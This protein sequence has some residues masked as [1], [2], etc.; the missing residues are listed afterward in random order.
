MVPSVLDT[1]RRAS[2]P[3]DSLQLYYP[4]SLQNLGDGHGMPASTRQM[5]SMTRSLS[6]SNATAGSLS[7][8]HHGHGSSPY[9]HTLDAPYPSHSRMSYGGGLGQSHHGGSGYGGMGMS[10]GSGGGGGGGLPGTS[11][12]LGSSSSQLY[13]S[14]GG[15]TQSPQSGA[16]MTI[17]QEE[18]TSRYTFPDHSASPQPGPGS[19][20]GTPQ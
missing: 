10:L 13:G 2:M 1:G 5:V 14:S 7:Q 17:Q 9:A 20:Y 3:T 4:M 15:Y 6:S 8:G 16:R 18:S 12:F 11:S 19:G